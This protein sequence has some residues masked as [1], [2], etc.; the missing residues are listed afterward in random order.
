MLKISVIIP[1][2]NAEKYLDRSLTSVIKALG[3]VPGEI[4]AVD[5]GS[6]DNSLAILEDYK[7]KYPKIIRVLHCKTHGAGAARNHGLSEAKGE[8]FWFIDADDEIKPSAILD[9]LGV[10]KKDKDLVM[11]GEEKIFPS[12][13][14]IVLSA[15]DPKEKDFKSRFVRYGMGPIQ[16][17]IRREW[18]NKNGF[19]FRETG[20][21]E[22][23]E[24]M[25]SLILYTDK[26]ASV[27][28][29]LYTY[30]QNPGSVIY[31]DKWDKVYLD[32]FPA[33]AGYY[34]RFEEMGV[35]EEYRDEV[36][37]YFIW[38]L[39]IDSTKDFSRFP[40]GKEGFK[41]TREMMKEYF[42]KWRKNQ[43]LKEKPLRLR[44]RVRLNY[45]K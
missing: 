33:L 9:L 2:F 11:L 22:D 28:K 13:E 23:V 18:W 44:I 12:G 14:R 27:D 5:N 10:A 21:H 3:K 1:V 31:K 36:E 35:L 29:V 45:Y 19:R 4:L 38:N 6:S 8:Y 41:K 37:W 7:K 39:L 30:Y 26:F 43:F 15:I 24:F 20:M 25:S 42:P 17:L 34:K 16:F 40:E 32:I